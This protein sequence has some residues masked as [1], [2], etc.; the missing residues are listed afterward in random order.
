VDPLDFA[1]VVALVR[2]V[3]LIV[4]LVLAT[5]TLLVVFWKVSGVLS[6]ARRTMKNVE[7]VAEAVSSRII[8]PA[9]AGSGVAFG[10]G[11]LAAFF[12]GFS[13]KRNGEG[14]DNGKR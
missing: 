3:L 12:M 1:E 9:A 5:M 11:K 13:K 2:D 14:E 4:V 8:G 10:A 7:D 6:S